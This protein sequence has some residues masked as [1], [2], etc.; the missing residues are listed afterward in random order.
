MLLHPAMSGYDENLLRNAPEATREER[1]VR[2]ASLLAIKKG[3]PRALVLSNPSLAIVLWFVAD[4]DD[5][6]WFY[7]YLLVVLVVYRKDIISIYSRQSAQLPH[8]RQRQHPEHRPYRQQAPAHPS[9]PLQ[10]TMIRSHLALTTIRNT[11]P[12]ARRRRAL[13]TEAPRYHFG[14]RQKGNC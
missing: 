13:S 3:Q 11:A 4:W 7:R 1:Q 10:A 9:L 2:T 6:D 8:R 12:S 14:E 5:A